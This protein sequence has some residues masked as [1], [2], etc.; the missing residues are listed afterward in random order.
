MLARGIYKAD[1]ER[2]ALKSELKSSK[3]S[4]TTLVRTNASKESLDLWMSDSLKKSVDRASV[5]TVLVGR[6]TDKIKFI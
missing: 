1:R 5:P 6:E 3:R 2:K 4:K